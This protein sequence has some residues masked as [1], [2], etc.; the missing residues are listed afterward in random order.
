M[1]FKDIHTN[2]YFDFRIFKENDIQD[3]KLENLND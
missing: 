3:I 2:K 1:I